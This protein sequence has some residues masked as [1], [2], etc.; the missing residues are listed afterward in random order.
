VSPS[1][2]QVDRFRADFERAFGAH[3]RG[4]IALAISGG[5]D[6]MAMLTLAAAAFRGQIIAATVDHGLRPESAD[7]AAMVGR[8]CEGISVPHTSLRITVPLHGNLHAWARRERYALLGQWAADAK[9]CALCTAHHADDQAETFLMRA[10]RASGLAG[11]AGVRMRTEGVV[12]V[13]RPLL[14]WRRA[15]LRALV[16]SAGLPFVDDPSNDDPRFDR[17]RFR[18]WLGQAP[19][20]DPRMVARSAEYLAEA[21]ADLRAVSDWL[22][23]E[24]AMAAPH[25]EVML[26][27]AD[28]PRAVRRSLARM[29]IEAVSGAAVQDTIESLLNALDAGKGASHSG[30]QASVKGNAWHFREAPPRRLH[31]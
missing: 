12:P 7:E 6:S 11:L 18:Q 10:A 27:V 17:A 1:S 13:V 22:W 4:P 23:I 15:E 25:G 29:A 5:P 28:L 26:D 24:R 8:T 2:E 16:E 14:S 21:E 20:I 9:A 19:W 30:V 31:R 3:L